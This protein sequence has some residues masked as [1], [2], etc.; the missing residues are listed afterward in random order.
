[1]PLADCACFPVGS[2]PAGR[3]LMG[4]EVTLPLNK[5]ALTQQRHQ[6]EISIRPYHAQLCASALFV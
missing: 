1:M 6:R 3:L 4:P 5:S 2:V